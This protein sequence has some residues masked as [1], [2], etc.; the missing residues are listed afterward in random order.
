MHQTPLKSK[1]EKDIA[2]NPKGAFENAEFIGLTQD[3]H[4]DYRSGDSQERLTKKFD[5]RIKHTIREHEKNPLWGFKSALTAPFLP[6]FIRHMQNPYV[7]CVLRNLLHNSLS[8][9]VQM[10]NIYGENI[11]LDHALDVMSEQQFVML[12]KL[13]EEVSC[14]THFLTYED[15]KKNSWKEAERLATFLKIPAHEKKQQV[16]EFIM[17]N[18]STLNSS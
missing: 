16:K 13:K 15:I 3:M 7:V 17:P 8:W 4:R 12:T 6:M 1:S 2:Q 11:T 18:Y 9:I 14:P 5:Q 10:R